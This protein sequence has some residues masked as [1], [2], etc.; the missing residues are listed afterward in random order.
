MSVEA[1]KSERGVVLAAVLMVLAA[2]SLMAV[3]GKGDA[4]LQWL[5][6][7]NSREYAEAVQLAHT[8]IGMA[9]ADDRFNIA[10]AQSGRY[11]RIASRCVEWT[12]THVETTPVPA[13]LDKR[14]EHQRALH[15]EIS[16]EGRAGNRARAPIVVGFVLITSGAM[17]DPL[18]GAIEICAKE[19]RCPDGTAGPPIRR[20]WREEAT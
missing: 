20:Y 13:G 7:R 14:P 15:F 12:V 4:A 9:L 8:G 16:A 10:A 3:T 11:C 2:L 6:V 19:D 17:D 18:P 1:A 5:Q